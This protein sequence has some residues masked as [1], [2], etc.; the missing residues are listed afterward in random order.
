[1]TTLVI[2]V[3]ILSNLAS[4][5]VAFIYGKKRGAAVSQKISAAAD[6]VKKAAS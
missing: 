6:V 5:V 1:M 4:A 3:L 2:T